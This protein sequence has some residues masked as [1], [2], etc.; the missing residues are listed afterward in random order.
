MVAR[1]SPSMLRSFIQSYVVARSSYDGCSPS[2]DQSWQIADS[3]RPVTAPVQHADPVPPPRYSADP[4]QTYV[5]VMS[6]PRSAVR[7]TATQNP[8]YSTVSSVPASVPASMPAAGPVPTP[9]SVSRS[10][11]LDN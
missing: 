5:K 11:S 2:Y 6:S 10:T 1:W 9:T 8:L 4:D 3:R 7:N